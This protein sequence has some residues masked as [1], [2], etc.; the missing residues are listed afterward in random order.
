MPPIDPPIAQHPALFPYLKAATGPLH[1]RLE[2]HLG[3]LRPP[4]SKARFVAV[5]ARFL[6]FHRG[7][8]GALRAHA[9]LAALCSGSRCRDA[10]RDLAA[11]G[12]S[13]A[14]LAQVGTCERAAGLL[15]DPERA[16]GAVYVVQGSTL[17]GV[18]IGRAIRA[19]PWSPPG[20]LHYF[21]PPDRDPEVAWARLRQWADSRWQPD[22]WPGIAAGARDTFVF[23]DEWLTRSHGAAE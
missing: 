1:G 15:T 13:R 14:E 5:L 9:P 18:A 12:V 4:L 17:G 16:M 3:L 10:E 21:S 11:L 7:W 23:L 19:Q 8:D 2:K 20:G 22:A 6:S